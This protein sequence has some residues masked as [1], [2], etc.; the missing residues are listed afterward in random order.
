MTD[1]FTALVAALLERRVRFVVIGVWAANYYA[2]S[3]G[4][5]FHT[6]DRDH[7]FLESHEEA[8][9]QMLGDD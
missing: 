3:G 9:R 7:L 8:L 4:A 2:P 5:V 1:T 6:E